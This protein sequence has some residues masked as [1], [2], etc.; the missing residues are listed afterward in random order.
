VVDAA[1][2]V[3]AQ[4]RHA[5]APDVPHPSFESPNPNPL[6]GVNGR[7]LRRTRGL[8][9]RERACVRARERG[10]GVIGGGIYAGSACQWWWPPVC[11]GGDRKTRREGIWGEREGR[12][13]LRFGPC[14][15]RLYWFGARL[16]VALGF[17][18]SAFSLVCV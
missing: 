16:P 18:A 12:D 13:V 14:S 5:V 3:A 1:V 9:K 2:L 11:V 6:A 17:H 7:R 8:E 10:G 15:G 4:R